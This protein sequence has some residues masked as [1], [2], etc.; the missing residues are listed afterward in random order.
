MRYHRALLAGLRNLEARYQAVNARM[1]IVRTL[2]AC[3]VLCSLEA[4]VVLDTPK[5]PT[6]LPRST[7]QLWLK[8]SGPAILKEIGGTYS[9]VGQ[10]SKVLAAEWKKVS[11]EEHSR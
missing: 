7:Y 4:R 3:V 2:T 1:Q 10:R 8:Q 6:K 9:N 5:V 11:E